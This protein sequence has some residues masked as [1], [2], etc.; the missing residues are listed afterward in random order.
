M[1]VQDGASAAIKVWKV[2]ISVLHGSQANVSACAG[3]AVVHSQRP[4][5]HIWPQPI[6]LLAVLFSMEF[7]LL[8]QN[9]LIEFYPMATEYTRKEKSQ[10]RQLA[11]EAWESELT[12]ELE[13]LFES[14][15][16]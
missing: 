13:K 15:C 10:L 3:K 11:R 5:R 8:L 12:G 2:P 6:I 4:E 16:T 7:A 14:F 1:S 9:V